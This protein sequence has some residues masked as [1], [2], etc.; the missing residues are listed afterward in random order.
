MHAAFVDHRISI[1]MVTVAPT[2]IMTGSVLVQPVFVHSH[3]L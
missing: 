1:S 3:L 2:P